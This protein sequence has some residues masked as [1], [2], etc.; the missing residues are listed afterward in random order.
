MRLP[1]LALALALVAWGGLLA[2]FVEG[3]FASSTAALRLA[4]TRAA[5][6]VFMDSFLCVEFRASSAHHLHHSGP[7]RKQGNFR[8]SVVRFSDPE[9]IVPAILIESFC[10][11]VPQ[12]G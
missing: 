9:T 7:L 12:S 3:D 5:D 8:H 11:V 10:R 2:S 6:L 1:L 4:L